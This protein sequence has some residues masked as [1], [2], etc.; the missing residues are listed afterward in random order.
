MR[1]LL[2]SF[3]FAF[4]IANLSAQPAERVFI[5]FDGSGSMWQQ[6]EG[7]Y[8]IA[9]ARTALGDLLADLPDDTEFGLLAYGHRRKDDCSDL[10][11][12]F[13]LGSLERETVTTAIEAMNPTGKTPIT[14]AV[15]Q[16]VAHLE[17]R[18]TTVILLSDGLETCEGDPCAA[19]RLAREAGRPLV[20]HVIGLGLEEDDVSQLECIAQAG[21]GQYYDVKDAEGLAG[22]LEQAVQEPE[23]GEKG[24]LSV[25]AVVN[26]ELEDVAVEVIREGEREMTAGGRTYTYPETNPR[27]LSL[28]AGRYSIHVAAVRFK[29]EARR[30]FTGLEIT[31]GDTLRQVVDFSTGQLVVGV[32]RNGALSDAA[33]SVLAHGERRQVDGA[34][35]YRSESSNPRVFELTPGV[36]DVTATSVEISGKI[37][38]RSDS[39]AVHP[40]QRQEVYFAFASGT[41]RV[42]V[43]QNGELIDAVVKVLDKATGRQVGGG[44]T[45]TVDTS[46]PL[47]VEVAPGAYR[48]VV[49]P[50]RP[51]GLAE[52]E[53]EV[54]VKPGEVTERSTT[55]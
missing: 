48:V 49:Q 42:G 30:I 1:L 5:I 20:F 3:L 11:L 41:L 37:V 39:V 53:F 26:G 24:Y 10:E 54:E 15:K 22:A 28:P 17:D 12:L 55:Y 34:R 9:L 44:R 4:R 8:K 52:K 6:M 18:E 25:K 46:N 35:T 2:L 14:A 29:G 27:I 21:G 32:T 40:G 31:A 23:E 43:S 45:Y 50:V 19:V 47:N 16:S 13:P 51:K 33:I 7:D 36:Y 38:Q